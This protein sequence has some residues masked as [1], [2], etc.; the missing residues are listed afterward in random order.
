[1]TLGVSS[2]FLFYYL[3]DYLELRT[4]EWLF[5]NFFTY[6]IFALIVIFQAEIRRGLAHLGGEGF[7]NKLNSKLIDII[8][9]NE[10]E[11][12]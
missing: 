11:I 10:P 8:I 1:M 4:V 3:I 9:N 6:F 2:L 5:A 7:L 12:F